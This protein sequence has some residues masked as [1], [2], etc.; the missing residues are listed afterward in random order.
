[1]KPR[2]LKGSSFHHQGWC[3]G[4]GG[5]G[6]EGGGQSGKKKVPCVGAADGCLGY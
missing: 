4:L 5:G 6:G 3:L 2:A 1:V